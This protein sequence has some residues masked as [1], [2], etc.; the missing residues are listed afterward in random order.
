[1][2]SLLCCLCGSDEPDRDSLL[3]GARNEARRGNQGQRIAVNVPEL[4]KPPTV[5][6]EETW[7]TGIVTV[8]NSKPS[9]SAANTDVPRLVRKF[10]LI[11]KEGQDITPKIGAP[12]CVSPKPDQKPHPGTGE[13]PRVREDEIIV[14]NFL[15]ALATALG[16]TDTRDHL[17]QHFW[18]FFPYVFPIIEDW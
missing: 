2:G 12:P 10:A 4:A 8:W 18:D 3:R 5:D 16:D 13:D 6:I 15:M 9:K 1:M 17:E 14:L 11:D 7:R